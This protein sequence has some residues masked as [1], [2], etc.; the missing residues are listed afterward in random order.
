[1]DRPRKEFVEK[2]IDTIDFFADS[3]E[4]E[5]DASGR[6]QRRWKRNMKKDDNFLKAES[7]VLDE[8]S[9]S[10]SIQQKR[11]SSMRIAKQSVFGQTLDQTESN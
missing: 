5:N 8:D 11:K 7:Q 1:M 6:K 9:K 3:D 4:E 2:N 10:Y